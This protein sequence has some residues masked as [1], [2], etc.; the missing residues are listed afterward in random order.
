M[1]ARSMSRPSIS[2]TFVKSGSDDNFCNPTST[3]FVNCGT[4]T[5]S[6]QEPSEALLVA[7]GGQHG[8]AGASGTCKFRADGADLVP[9]DGSV[10]V[11][12]P[13]TARTALR[14]NGM[15]LTAV[16]DVGPELVTFEL[17]CNETSDDV[18]FSIPASPP[19]RSAARPT[20]RS[21]R[22]AADAPGGCP[23]FWCPSARKGRTVVG[24]VGSP[25]G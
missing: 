12:D 11:G 22:T 6:P 25:P 17:V 20:E 13:A 8:T 9:D 19:W 7:G 15:G 5:L 10:S 23:S 16:T 24:R 18:A 2:S 4:V 3:T 1:P 21:S 14:T